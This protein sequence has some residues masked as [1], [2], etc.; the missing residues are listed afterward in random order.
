[1][2]A[3]VGV[4]GERTKGARAEAWREEERAEVLIVASRRIRRRAQRHGAI[5]VVRGVDAA[6]R[7]GLFVEPEQ[8]VRLPRVRGDLALGQRTGLVPLLGIAARADA[9]ARIVAEAV[10]GEVE[11]AVRR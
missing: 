11:D 8:H 3:A 7:G 1:G 10:E 9:P 4:R 5:R 6:T 2:G